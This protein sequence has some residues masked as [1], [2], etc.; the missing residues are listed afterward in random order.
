MAIL[1]VITVSLSAKTGEFKKKMLDASKTVKNMGKVGALAAGAFGAGVAGAA[2]LIT[3]RTLESVDAMVKLGRA[4]GLTAPEMAAFELAASRGGISAE[5]MAKASRRL[6]VM[7]R[8]HLIKPSEKTQAVLERLG[9]TN[10][11]VGASYK[12][13]VALMS[14]MADGLAKIE[15][16][17]EKAAIA[18][19]LFGN[20]G[21]AMLNVIGNGSQGLRDAAT[22]AREFGLAISDEAGGA[23]ENLNDRLADIG[24]IT[25][26][27]SRQIV[28]GLAPALL[29]LTEQFIA[30]VRG[31]A[32]ARGGIAALAGDL[33]KGLVSSIGQ[34]IIALAEMLN[35][36][37][38]T[39]GF[40]RGTA[41]EDLDLFDTSGISRIVRRVN[42]A[43]DASVSANQRAAGTNITET[44]EFSS[45]KTTPTDQA[46]LKAL[47]EIARNTRETSAV[48]G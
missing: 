40:L 35:S 14:L 30:W 16:G 26:G 8:D 20:R 44:G 13:S 27:F 1:R 19:T 42:E 23:V 4:T 9:I 17:G 34:V 22:D 18:A 32:E 2:A 46:I 41:A 38:R 33:V 37:K 3:S 5:E 47:D 29:D 24:Q 45:T 28:T 31:L 39:L 21:A 15:D 7:M 12:D 36:I 48:A 6:G 25:V 11:Q 10:M 43:V